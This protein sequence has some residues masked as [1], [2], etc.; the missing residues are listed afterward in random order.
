MIRI[1]AVALIWFLIATRAVLAQQDVVWVQIEAADTLAAARER[2][3]AYSAEVPD[4]NGFALAN[5]TYGISLGPYARPDAERVLRAY[6]A[7]G[8]IPGDSF[9]IGAGSFRQ[10]FWPRGANLRGAAPAEPAVDTV[11]P[12]PVDDTVAQAPEVT[13]QARPDTAPA[14]PREETLREARASER[15]LTRAERDA[16]QIAL[17]WAGYYDHAIDGAIG[18]GTRAAMAEWQRKNG[19]EATG[20]LTT[21]QRAQLLAQYNAVL[22]GLDLRMVRD[23]RAGIEMKLPMGVV[24]F[25][26]AQSPFVH[27]TPTG[28]VQARVLL[29]S[30]PG[31]RDTLFGL[32]DI[33]QTLAIV[34]P[35]GPRERGRDSFELVGIGSD[36]ISHTQASLRNGRI[37][38]FTLV[39]PTGDDARRGRLL[40]EMQTSFTPIDGVLDPGTGTDAAQDVDL[41]SGLEIRKP[42]LSR[43]GFYTDARGTVVTTTQA[44]EECTRITYDSGTTAEV[45]RSDATLGVAVLR[46]GTPL[47]PPTVAMLRSTD[48]RLQSDVAVAGYS[49]GGDLGAPTVT[50][51]KLA[52][53]NGLNGETYLS[54]LALDALPGDAGGPVVDA[55]GTVLGMLLPRPGEGT[56]KLPEGVQFAANA[57]AIAALLEDAG[58]QARR[59]E[60]QPR[61]AP[62]A[63]TDRAAAMTVLVNCWDE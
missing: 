32:Y 46:P 2:A 25:D 28:E 49:Y 50:F 55:G 47:A 58:M 21:R 39:W 54:R 38:G 62:E 36:F 14:E 57:D 41:V 51:G 6:R 43:S 5:G 7:E 63:L 27:Y 34:P 18:P 4:V 37:K 31:D 42:R 35:E 61:L 40:R 19:F 17:K 44:V 15:Q 13:Q 22:E 10:Q 60:A 11:A 45:V 29:I 16:L 26:R 52:D 48:P 9:L 3:R 59:G 30:Q 23:E 12:D 53:I 20:V 8:V 24:E 33:M 56:R 1:L